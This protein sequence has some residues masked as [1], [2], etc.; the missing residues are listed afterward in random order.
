MISGHDD[1]T[2]FCM[3]KHWTHPY[4]TLFGC[5]SQ[6]QKG[7]GTETEGSQKLYSPP[8]SPKS[9]DFPK[10]QPDWCA[11]HSNFSQEDCATL[12]GNFPS[13]R[14]LSNQHVTLEGRLGSRIPQIEGAAILRIRAP[15]PR[16]QFWVRLEEG[17]HRKKKERK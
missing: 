1:Q 6:L 16:T 9:P 12:S 14:E 10:I 5:C 4:S 2:E 3:Q 11:P 13:C 15:F 8:F 7:R 17:V